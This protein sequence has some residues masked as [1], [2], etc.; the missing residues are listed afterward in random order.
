MMWHLQT[1]DPRKSVGYFDGLSLNTE[2]FLA[3]KINVQ[4]Q[5]VR[6]R[7]FSVFYISSHGCLTDRSRV[8]AT[9][10]SVSQISIMFSL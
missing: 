1:G 3:Q 7:E 9:S 8:V 5:P 6:Q 10:C 4:P 2:E